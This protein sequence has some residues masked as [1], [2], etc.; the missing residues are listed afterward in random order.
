[1]QFDLPETIRPL[2]KI[3]NLDEWTKVPFTFLSKGSKNTYTNLVVV[4]LDFWDN[5]IP[6]A[7]RMKLLLDSIE[8]PSVAFLLFN[9][10]CQAMT[11]ADPNVAITNH[12]AAKCIDSLLYLLYAE[13]KINLITD[14]LHMFGVGFG[15]NVCLM[16]SKTCLT[17]R[18]SCGT[19]TSTKAHCFC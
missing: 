4:A 2:I 5:Y 18:P 17:K 3:A 8:E 19:P 6:I 12:E 1:M 11:V 14:R 13:G 15:A 9:Y 7:H 16:Y 10:P